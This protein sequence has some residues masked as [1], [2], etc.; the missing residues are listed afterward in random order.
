M[1]GSRVHGRAVDVDQQGLL[2][3]HVGRNGNDGGLGE[4]APRVR[5]DAILGDARLTDAG[6]VAPHSGHGDPALARNDLHGGSGTAQLGL[7]Q[8]LETL[9]RGEPPVLELA[10]EL[11]ELFHL[12]GGE[13]ARAR[14]IGDTGNVTVLGVLDLR[15]A[16]LVAALLEN[17]TFLAHARDGHAIL[18]RGDTVHLV[19]GFLTVSYGLVGCGHISQRILPSAIRSSG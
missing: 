6:V 16:G 9:D 12:V 5:G 10:G 19:G 2:G 15:L 8:T 11:G 1:L 17:L 4:R 13:T 7:V 14:R 18:A 3:L